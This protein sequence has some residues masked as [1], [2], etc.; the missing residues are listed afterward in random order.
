MGERCSVDSGAWNASLPD[1]NAAIKESQYLN[2]VNQLHQLPKQL[3]EAKILFVGLKK[4]IKRSDIPTEQ[5]RVKRNADMTD[6]IHSEMD[7]LFSLY[8]ARAVCRS[9]GS[10]STFPSADAWEHISQHPGY[11]WMREQHDCETP[12]DWMALVGKLVEEAGWIRLR[13]RRRS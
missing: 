3:L 6:L 10:C 1:I 11:C 7:L 9:E 13:L 12:V 8:L 5:V 2:K 4:L